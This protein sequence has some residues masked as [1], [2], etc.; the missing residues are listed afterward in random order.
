MLWTQCIRSLFIFCWEA[1]AIKNNVPFAERP[2]PSKIMSLLLR[3]Q[4]HQ[5]FPLLRG[6]RHQ[7]FPLLRGQ[8]HQMFPLLRGQSHQMFP[9]P[10]FLS[11]KS[12]IACFSIMYTTLKSPCPCFDYSPMASSNETPVPGTISMMIRMVITAAPKGRERDPATQASSL[13][14]VTS[15]ILTSAKPVQKCILQQTWH[16]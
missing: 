7:M 12:H 3:G 8:R 6:Q 14:Y 4:R 10:S 2:E 11:N 9:L 13:Y 16:D 5:I 1:R 15:T